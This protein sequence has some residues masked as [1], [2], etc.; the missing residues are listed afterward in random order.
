MLNADWWRGATIYQIYLRSFQDSNDDGVGDL[1]GIEQRLPYIKDLGVDAIWICPF[2]KSPQR[3]FG[4]DVQDYDSV[5]PQYGTL[6]HFQQLLERAHGLGLRVIIDQ[7]WSHTSNQ[8][9]WFQESRL[10]DCG[11]KADWYVWAD[12]QCDGTPPNNWLSVFG[13]AAWT[14]DAK[15]RQYYMH[16]F[17]SEQP[18]LNLKHPQVVNA[19]LASGKRW[20]DMGVDGFRL[21]AVD[22]MM[23]D[24][25]LRNNP[26]CPYLG[27]TPAKLFSLQEHK[28]DVCQPQ[29]IDFL[30]SVR[31]LVDQYPGATTLGE[32]SSQHGSNERIARYTQA[33]TGL[34][35]AYTLKHMKSEFSVDLMRSMLQSDCEGWTCWSFSN[36]DAP[37]VA[38][39]WAQGN[40]TKV[41]LLNA[42]LMCLRG[43]VCLY[44]GE[45][46]G[47]EEAQI[48]FD[49]VRDP[50]GISHW[51][52]FKGR[53]GSRT[54]MPWNNHSPHSGFSSHAP[55]LPIPP[56]HH[57][58]AAS[59]QHHATSCLSVV[60]Q[61]VQNRNTHVSLKLGSVQ[62]L[63]SS[64]HVLAFVR[65]AP[66]HSKV[67]C[68]FNFSDQPAVFAHQFTTMRNTATQ[69]TLDCTITIEPYDFVVAVEHV[70]VDDT[71]ITI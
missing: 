53:D 47:L 20:L 3:D 40:M 28:Y 1:L 61:A 14:W 71:D 12:P 35:M 68:V 23:Y 65:H 17:L 50:F 41:N 42:F 6:K 13:G 60:Q 22:W 2:F 5:D 48:S 49:Q 24:S 39:R 31:K 33:H 45:E 64:D 8:H 57:G 30:L 27:K 15:R 55:W 69:K 36:H 70:L 19:L 63:D 7:V 59:T 44:Q 56:Q 51:P 18:S 67:L 54:P 52:D 32:V 34:H 21:D 11:N 29:V 4:Y 66:E 10:A 25:D 62:T 43:T 46:L 58:Q 16:H 9:A 38:T 26:A 37:R